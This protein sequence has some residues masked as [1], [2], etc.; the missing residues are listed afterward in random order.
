MTEATIKDTIRTLS[1]IR[2]TG[3]IAEGTVVK[4][5]S[6]IYNYAAV[7]A[8]GK[9]WITGTGRWYGGNVFTTDQFKEILKTA[10]TASIATEWADL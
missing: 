2:K 7:Y 3:R 10:E 6:S 9:W 4:W 1:K 8:G 5:K